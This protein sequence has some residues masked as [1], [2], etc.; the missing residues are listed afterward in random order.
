MQYIRHGGTLTHQ[1]LPEV[2]MRMRTGG[3]STGVAQYH[4]AESGDL[5]GL[6]GDWNCDTSLESPFKISGQT[7]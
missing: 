2:L 5:A 7:A 3:V 6:S 4:P 1:H